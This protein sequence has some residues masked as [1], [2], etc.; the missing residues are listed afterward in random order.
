[1]SITTH[2]GTTKV[3]PKSVKLNGK[4]HASIALLK[5]RAAAKAKRDGAILSAKRRSARLGSPTGRVADENVGGWCQ[6]MIVRSGQSF[7][8]IADTAGLSPTTVSN[9]LYG[10]TQ[11]PSFNTVMRVL[12]VGDVQLEMR[13]RP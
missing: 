5:Q 12:S 2:V 1:M 9:L 10:R 11:R 7:S 3:A 13:P 4:A 6:A 8:R